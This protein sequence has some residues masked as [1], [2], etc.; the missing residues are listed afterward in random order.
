[1][2]STKTVQFFHY[3]VKLKIINCFQVVDKWKNILLFTRLISSN[4]IKTWIQKKQAIT[5]KK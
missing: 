5:S 3:N 2:K 4:Q 1:M